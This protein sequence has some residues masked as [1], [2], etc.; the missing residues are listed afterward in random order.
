MVLAQSSNISPNSICTLD[1][2][3]VYLCLN[4]PSPERDIRVHYFKSFPSLFHVSFHVAFKYSKNAHLEQPPLPK[5]VRLAVRS[6]N[7]LIIL[8]ILLQDSIY[9][10][11]LHESR[12]RPNTQIVELCSVLQNDYQWR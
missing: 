3:C 1:V 11:L 7:P 8:R 2:S 9:S 12:V 10:N 4:S 5:L 6:D